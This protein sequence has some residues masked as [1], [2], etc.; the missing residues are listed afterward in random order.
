MIGFSR[1]TGDHGQA[2]PHAARTKAAGDQQSPHGS[3]MAVVEF[4]LLDAH[5]PAL[6][7]PIA[8]TGVSEGPCSI[9]G[10]AASDGDP[11]VAL[12]LLP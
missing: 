11:A 8:V 9:L 10:V 2:F 3:G 6:V 12:A 4:H 1:D 7:G 5:A